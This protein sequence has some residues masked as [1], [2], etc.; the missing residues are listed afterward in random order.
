M[1]IVHDQV[2]RL[3]YEQPPLHSG[4]RATLA[5]TLEDMHS[6]DR[7]SFMAGLQR[8]QQADHGLY[9]NEFRILRPSGSVRWLG[10]NGRVEF[11]AARRPLRL[12]GI[13]MDI[14]LRKRAKAAVRDSEERLQLAMKVTRDVVWEWRADTDRMRWNE[15]GGALLGETEPQ[16][17]GVPLAWWFERMHPGA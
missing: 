9:R 5:R 1:G 8:A 17:G 2:R 11:D 16:T 7:D 14:M 12:G 15:V 6:A 4:Q 13:S 3:H 10:E